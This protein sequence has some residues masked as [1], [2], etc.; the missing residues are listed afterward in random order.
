MIIKTDERDGNCIMLKM[1]T[2]DTVGVIYSVC[3]MRSENTKTDNISEFFA[4]SEE[5]AQF[6]YKLLVD[7][8]AGNYPKK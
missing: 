6:L 2:D 5:D 7:K 4:D 3:V 8:N 1:Y